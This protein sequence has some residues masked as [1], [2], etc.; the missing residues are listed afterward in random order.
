MKY[1]MRL[2]ELSLRVL[3]YVLPI[4]LMKKVDNIPCSMREER[5]STVDALVVM[6]EA[7]ERSFVGLKL[8]LG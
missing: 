2:P 4:S 3:N 6:Q 5:L 1:E 8:L 7:G